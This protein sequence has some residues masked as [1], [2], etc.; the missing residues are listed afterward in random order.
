MSCSTK[1]YLLLTIIHSQGRQIG[2]LFAA[3]TNR[4]SFTIRLLQLLNSKTPLQS[5]PLPVPS[6]QQPTTLATTQAPQRAPAQPQQ[7]QPKTAREIADEVR[8]AG[9]DVLPSTSTPAHTPTP[10][11]SAAEQSHAQEHLQKKREAKQER[12]RIRKQIE[13]DKIERRQRE[14]DRKAQEHNI[15]SALPTVPKQSTSSTQHTCS[16]QIR[17]LDG[18]TKRANFPA[19][20]I[21]RDTVRP[22]IASA[23]DSPFTV[24]LICTPQPSRPLSDADE[25]LSLKDLGLLPSATLVLVP[26]QRYT[27]AYDSSAHS[28]MGVARS[29]AYRYIFAC[30]DL[31][32]RLVNALF[33][34]ITRHDA[35]PPRPQTD[36]AHDDAPTATTTGIRIRTLRDRAEAEEEKQF[37]NGN[38]VSALSCFSRSSGC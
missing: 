37:Y 12:D 7:D 35:P 3:G 31:I 18:S 36:G 4:N 33:G 26:I 17:L 8:Q 16:L 9:Q 14:L 23:T 6:S 20:S 28:V 15:T 24:K 25:A 29:V 21:L 32:A 38:Q 13:N 27:S 2:Q 11:R 1:N 10:I 22:W 5:Q 34:L 30:F 19:T